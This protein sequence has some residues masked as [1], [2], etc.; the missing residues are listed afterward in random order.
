MK[1]IGYFELGRDDFVE[2]P[3]SMNPRLKGLTAEEPSIKELA[4][5]IARDGQLQRI[6]TRILPNKKHEILDGDRRAIAIF[7]VLHYP[8]IKAAVY[9]MNDLEAA[10]M[11]LVCNLQR[12]DLSPVEKGKYC[13]DLF[14]VMALF[15]NLD[16]EKSW[17][18][19]LV[20]S[21]LLS[22]ISMEIGVTPT[23][24][25]NWVR[26]WQTFPPYAQKLIATNKEDLRKGLIAPSKALDAAQLARQIGVDAGVILQ[27]IIENGWATHDIEMA[28]SC[29]K[30]GE[31]INSENYVTKINE[32]KKQI[33]HYG[34]LILDRQDAEKFKELIRE[35]HLTFNEGMYYSV[36]FCLN[37]S[38]EFRRF[39]VKKGIT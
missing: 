19:R 31:D 8:T 4:N 17:A 7:D 35:F 39:L 22:Q 33:R 13:L 16:P 3:S 14:R 25:I 1:F 2:I 32:I 15:E 27:K 30:R 36:K 28:L 10:R 26:L 20:R 5:S 11:R 29:I 37:H 18:D 23:T 12:Q 38:S 21:R 9:E 6:I 24:I 34:R